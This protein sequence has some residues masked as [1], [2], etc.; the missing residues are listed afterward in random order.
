MVYASRHDR[1]GIR[2]DS[3]RP[4]D[5]V[6]G[7]MPRQEEPQL[8]KSAKNDDNR[9]FVLPQ[10][11]ETP[12]KRTQCGYRDVE[13]GRHI[14]NDCYA[15]SGFARTCLRTRARFLTLPASGHTCG[16]NLHFRHLRR[17]TFPTIFKTSTWTRT[18]ARPPTTSLTAGTRAPVTAVR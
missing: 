16:C 15:A 11:L 17:R 6:S 1:A 14:T 9:T 13:D 2:S 7:S 5:G 10:H 12:S 4:P 8:S 3:H 18:S